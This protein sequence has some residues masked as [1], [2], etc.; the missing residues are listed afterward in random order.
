M[1]EVRKKP[2]FKKY[3]RSI[4]LVDYWKEYGCSDLCCPVGDDD[5]EC[6]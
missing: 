2:W 3:V 6:D 4:G 1:K 5:F